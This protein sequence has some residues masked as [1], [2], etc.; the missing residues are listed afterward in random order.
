[1]QT[2]LGSVKTSGPEN[3][4]EVEVEVT[5][6]DAA[7]EDALQNLRTKPPKVDSTPDASTMQEDYYRNFRTNVLLA[8]TLS[9]VS[10]PSC[11]GEDMI[12]DSDTGTFSCNCSVDN[13][14]W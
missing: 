10:I 5:D 4:Q 8:W 13:Q 1:M 12:A 11:L 9:N 2:D 14:R 6:K 7:Y 3:K